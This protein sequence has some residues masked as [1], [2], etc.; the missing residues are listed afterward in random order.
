MDGI[1]CFGQCHFETGD[2][3]IGSMG[4]GHLGF[5]VSPMPAW[6]RPDSSVR[7]ASSDRMQ[8]RIGN[9]LHTLST[10]LFFD[11]DFYHHRIENDMNCPKSP[12]DNAAADTYA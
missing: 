1:S 3:I 8:V 12:L 10:T 4:K 2:Y 9:G 5:V 11:Y 6:P 7:F